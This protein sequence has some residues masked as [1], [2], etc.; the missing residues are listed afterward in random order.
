MRFI[1]AKTPAG[2]RVGIVRADGRV[3]IS[4]DVHRLETYFGDDGEA[5]AQLG[6]SIHANPPANTTSR[7]STSSSQWTPSLCATS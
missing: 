7:T 2:A 3:E 5:L 4:S 1:K 6:E